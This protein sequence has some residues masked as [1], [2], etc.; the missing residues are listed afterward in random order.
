MNHRNVVVDNNDTER[1]TGCQTSVI[2]KRKWISV[3]L[4]LCVE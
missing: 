1:K 4:S 3:L 2:R